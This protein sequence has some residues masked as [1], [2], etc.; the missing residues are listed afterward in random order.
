MS[1][2]WWANKLGTAPRPA[3]RSPQYEPAPRTPTGFQPPAPFGSQQQQYD[4]QPEQQTPVNEKGE[5]EAGYAM[6]AWQG[7]QAAQDGGTCP[8]CGSFRFM[9]RMGPETGKINSQGQ[10][11]YPS[12]ECFECGYPKNQG[13]L[14]AAAKPIG[15]AAPARQDAASVQGTWASAMDHLPK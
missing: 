5:V 13:S 3:P 1:G 15:G 4:Y 2:N 12:P 8:A 14:G 10:M 11:V 6:R 7:T 9:S